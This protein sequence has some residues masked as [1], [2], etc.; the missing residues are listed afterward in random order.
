M[1]L[2]S[3]GDSD[4]RDR[5]RSGQPCTAVSS[6]NEERFD[7][8]IRANRRITTR[9]LCTELNV[10]SNF[11]SQAR[12]EETSLLQHVNASLKTMK[13]VAKFGRTV[14]PH[15]PY[16]PDLSP[17]DFQLFGPMKDGLRSQYFPYN[18]TVIAAVRKRVV[19][20]GA[21]FYER[22]MQARSSL[23]KMHNQ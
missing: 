18:D 6:Q 15:P 5:P 12:K 19:S 2:F 9:E 13:H 3:S 7:Q 23:A 21:D 10:G 4:M 22:K 1:V 17:S 14:L 20:A 11:Q 16:S 8:I